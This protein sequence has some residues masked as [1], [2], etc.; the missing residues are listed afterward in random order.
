[1]KLIHNKLEKTVISIQKKENRYFFSNILLRSFVKP[2]SN[3]NNAIDL[4][5]SFQNEKMAAAKQGV[6]QRKIYQNMGNV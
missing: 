6:R 4:E 5:N 2:E 1:M 3:E